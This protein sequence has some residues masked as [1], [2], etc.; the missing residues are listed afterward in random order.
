MRNKEWGISRWRIPHKET[1]QEKR[2]IYH[3]FT[4]LKEY[5][6]WKF[7]PKFSSFLVRVI[8]YLLI[9]HMRNSKPRKLTSLITILHIQ[10]SFFSDQT[11]IRHSSSSSQYPTL[12]VLLSILMLSTLPEMELR[13]MGMLIRYRGCSISIYQIL[14]VHS[15]LFLK[16]SSSYKVLKGMRLL[17]AQFS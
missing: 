12:L 11:L 10:L 8:N 14:V 3:E 16:T 2:G 4:S 6:P 15:I 9:S 7:C 13:H 5:F 17:I 1:I